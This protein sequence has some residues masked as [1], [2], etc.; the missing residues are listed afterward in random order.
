MTTGT[1]AHC[2]EGGE[3]NRRH[4]QPLS[5]KAQGEGAGGMSGGIETLG[6]RQQGGR[7]R[8]RRRRVGGVWGGEEEVVVE[9]TKIWLMRLSLMRDAVTLVIQ[10]FPR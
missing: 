6:R 10:K 2:K 4:L 7:D 5:R 9:G 8:R 1:W 3:A